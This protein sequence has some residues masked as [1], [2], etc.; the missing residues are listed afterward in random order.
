MATDSTFCT[1]RTLVN[2]NAQ[3]HPN[4]IAMKE[5]ETGKSCT[6]RELQDRVNRLGNALRRLNVKKGDR[7][8]ILSQNSYE[9]MESYFG[10]TC[11]GFVFVPVNFRL[12]AGEAASVLTDAEPVVLFVERQYVNVAMEIK[13]NVPSV[14]EFIFIGPENEKPEGWHAYENLISRASDIPL[15][16]DIFED[17]LAVLMYTSGTTGLPK[18]VMQ[19]HLNHYHQ[20]RACALNNRIETEDIGFNICPMYHVT[21]YYSF[22]GPFYKGATNHIFQKWDAEMLLKTAQ[23]EHL[24]AGMFAT[25]MIR[26]LLDAYPG[27]KGK[28]DISSLKKLWFA[29]AGIVPSIYKDFIDT[30][31]CILGEHHGT[32]ETT[33]VT[34]NLA[35]GDIEAELAKGNTKILESCGKASFDLEI[36]IVDDDGHIV[37]QPG[38]GEMRARG[39]GVT[40]GYWHK[41]V[42]TKSAFKDGW[43]YTEDICN[44][45]ENGYIYVIDR[46]KDMIITGGENV[47]PLE[48]EKVINSHP[49]VLESSAIGIPHPVWGEKIAAILVLKEG[50]QTTEEEII[51]Y[52]KGKIAGYKVPKAVYFIDELPRSAP[53]KILKPELRARYSKND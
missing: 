4:K 38:I 14:K 18:G 37:E 34:T 24:T 47:Y 19:T 1:I 2:R 42:Q 41:E 51:K 53:G 26:M 5:V 44:I 40:H 21:G 50:Q 16:V 27:L 12:A 22:L 49:T 3:L 45:D 7:V 6:F 13:F 35:A 17:H 30:F 32:T 28:Y 11:A 48:I 20:G 46:K 25:P 43:F 23:E 29:G 39:L 9:Y 36:N 8:G 10:V 33:G 31:G 52:C 15:N